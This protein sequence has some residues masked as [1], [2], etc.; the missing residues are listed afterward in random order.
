MQWSQG[1]M[2]FGL[3]GA[4]FA[5]MH[6]LTQIEFESVF[7]HIGIASL[8][9]ACTLLVFGSLA[10]RFLF[11]QM[12]LEGRTLWLLRLSPRGP[13]YLLYGKLWLYSLIAVVV[14]EGLLWLSM[15]RLGVP[16]MMQRWLAGVGLVASVTLVAMMVG[17][18][19]WWMD[20]TARDPARVVSSS[21][22]ALALV[23][24]L[25]YIGCVVW[26]LVMSWTSWVHS[27]EAGFVLSTL[28]MIVVSGVCSVVPLHYGLR[29]LEHQSV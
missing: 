9:L 26:A 13:R 21:S 27:S 28:G 2:F 7:W 17:L 20:P 3:L 5:N 12:S 18:G 10:V 23:G 8:N 6:R 24:M 29:R 11:P 4:Y 15:A 16:V 1:V 14:I 25:G 22:G 19:A